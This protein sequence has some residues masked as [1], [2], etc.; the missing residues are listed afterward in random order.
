MSDRNT[1]RH[2]SV[3]VRGLAQ[4]I[5]L[6]SPRPGF[7]GEG[8]T[9]IHVIDVR[10]FAHNDPFI[11]LADDRIDLPPGRRAGGPHL[12]EGHR[13]GRTSLMRLFV[14]PASPWVRRVRVMILE[15]GIED[16]FEFIQTR[17]PHSWG[18]A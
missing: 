9:A 11:I 1:E 18:N 17:W 7:I 4:V 6:P 14:T 13:T 12:P 3:A 5:T 16:R 2:S 10:D 8:H 15:L